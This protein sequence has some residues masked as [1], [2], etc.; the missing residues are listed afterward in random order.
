M[1]TRESQ[2]ALLYTLNYVTYFL[3]FV[4]LNIEPINFYH[5]ALFL[6]VCMQLHNTTWLT[7]LF[8]K[9]GDQVAKPYHSYKIS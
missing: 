3:K 2:I 5:E 1:H 4:D 9:P 8:L 6:Y 7:F